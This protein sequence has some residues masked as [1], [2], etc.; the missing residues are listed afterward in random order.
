MSCLQQELL[1]RDA[2]ACSATALSIPA[3][4]M[5]DDALGLT[6]V[7]ELMTA[8][9]PL[10]KT[11]TAHRQRQCKVRL[12]HLLHHDLMGQTCLFYSH[13]KCHQTAC[14]SPLTATSQLTSQL[15][16]VS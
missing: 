9:A 3:H 2:A 7:E 5:P 12:T 14:C 11:D 13:Q 6:G 4:S 1:A 8:L 15:N 16:F 10:E